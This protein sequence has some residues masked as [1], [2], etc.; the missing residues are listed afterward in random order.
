MRFKRVGALSIALSECWSIRDHSSSG[1]VNEHLPAPYGHRKCGSP[2]GRK[3][4]LVALYV[5]IRRSH[6]FRVSKS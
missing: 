1:K 4:V 5:C 6:D 3:A 2:E